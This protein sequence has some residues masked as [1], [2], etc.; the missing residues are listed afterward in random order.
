MGTPAPAL[1]RSSRLLFSSP[2]HGH[3]RQRLGKVLSLLP[4]LPLP[5]QRHCCGGASPS[6]APATARCPA[7][8]PPPPTAPSRARARGPA[9]GPTEAKL[10]RIYFTINPA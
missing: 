9:P 6:C 3:L 5:L 7:A 10:F 4:L 2:L 8:S 1:S